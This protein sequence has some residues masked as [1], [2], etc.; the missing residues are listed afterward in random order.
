M[1]AQQAAHLRMLEALPKRTHEWTP[2]R[3][4]WGIKRTPEEN[5]KLA[6]E[7]A[8]AQDAGMSREVMKATF[9]ISQHTIEKL[10]G[11]TKRGAK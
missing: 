11:L 8:E 6:R 10:I 3:G 9:N 7:L 1:T 5:A 4:Q 2:T